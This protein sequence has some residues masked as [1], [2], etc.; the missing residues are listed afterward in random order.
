MYKTIYVILGQDGSSV[1]I[2]TSVAFGKD[3]VEKTPEEVKPI[4]LKA[5]KEFL[6]HWPDPSE[7]KCQKWR[8]SQVSYS[9]IVVS[10]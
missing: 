8:F 10:D 4:L 5:V 6:P 3:H 7:V 9:L 2:H 1:V